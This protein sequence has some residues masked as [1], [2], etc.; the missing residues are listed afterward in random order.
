[1]LPVAS[2]PPCLSLKGKVWA[3]GPKTKIS[4]QRTFSYPRGTEGKDKDKDREIEDQGEG[5]ENKGE[6]Q[7]YL[8]RTKD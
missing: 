2:Q 6:E 3:Q 8:R 4:A 1:M 5:Q 7:G